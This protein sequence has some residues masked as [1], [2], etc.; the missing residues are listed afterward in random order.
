MNSYFQLLVV[1][2]QLQITL[3]CLNT[4]NTKNIHFSLFLANSK[5]KK[6]FWLMVTYNTTGVQTI[7]TAVIIHYYTLLQINVFFGGKILL[8]LFQQNF[9]TRIYSNLILYILQQSFKIYKVWKDM[10]NDLQGEWHAHFI[11][12]NVQTRT[13]S[14][15]HQSRSRNSRR[16]NPIQC[17]YSR[18]ERIPNVFIQSRVSKLQSQLCRLKGP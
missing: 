12:T 5:L 7:L 1:Y 17:Q 6:S 9:V 2:F 18:G 14:Q 8:K 13:D 10:S 4:F 3:M 11:Y 15:H 16:I